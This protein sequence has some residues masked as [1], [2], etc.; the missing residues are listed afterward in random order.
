MFRCNIPEINT[1][2]IYIN[3]PKS[4]LYNRMMRMKN[5]EKLLLRLTSEEKKY[6]LGKLKTAVFGN[7]SQEVKVCPCCGKDNFK[8]DGKYKGVQKYKCRITSKIFSYK[9]DTIISNLTKLD[10]MEELMVFMLERS[11]PTIDEI[12][13]HIGISRQ[14][15]HDWR[16]KILTAVYDVIDLN[17]QVIEF[18]E[19]NLRISRKGRKGMLYSRKSGKK[20]VGDNN[21]NVKVFMSYSRTTKKL[22]LFQSHMGRS[23]SQD[24]EN[25]LG[26]K[27]GVVVYSDKH[28]S[29]KKYCEKHGIVQKTFKSKDRVSKTNK[30]VHNQNINY[31]C[32][33]LDTFLNEDLRGVSTKYLQGYLNWYMFVQNVVKKAKK[34]DVLRDVVIK[35]KVALN[36]YK[37]KEKEFA[38]FLKINGRNNYGVCRDRYYGKVA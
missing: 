2:Y 7:I 27:K 31:H 13:K 36:I 35:N 16:T 4:S 8:K 32:K 9:S 18:D 23:S 38:Y 20:L 30:E 34:K 10:K 24:V 19:T 33:E 17:S 12:Q 15:A 28:G 21:Y 6:L 29:Y 14:T 5:I 11:F 37:Q 22:E 26:T 3:F 1:L 25:Y